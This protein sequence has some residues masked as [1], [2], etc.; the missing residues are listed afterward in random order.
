ML[1][2]ENNKAMKKNSV[3][4]EILDKLISDYNTSKNHAGFH[5]M[6]MAETV[7]EAEQ[8]LNKRL[9]RRFLLKVRLKRVQASKL[10]AIYQFS[11]NDSRLADFFNN[12][13]VEKS[14]LITTIKDENLRTNFAETIIDVPFTVKQTKQAVY[15]IIAENKTPARAVEE[16]KNKIGLS[17]QKPQKKTVPLEEFQKLKTEYEKLLQKIAELEQKPPEK[18]V[19]KN[20]I[21]K[22]QT[23]LNLGHIIPA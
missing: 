14:Y 1:S 12:E 13:G 9:F 15:K 6:K 3:N 22:G 11:K 17:Q 5:F 2:K 23:T 18:T 21:V 19:P 7:T 8:K 10:I 4:T 20:E 16:V